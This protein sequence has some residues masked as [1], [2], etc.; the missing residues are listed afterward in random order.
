MEDFWR[1]RQVLEIV[2]KK[3]QSWAGSGG[4]SGILSTARLYDWAAGAISN[5]QLKTACAAAGAMT[6]G[7][8]SAD[9]DAGIRIKQ[10]GA[11]RI[12]TGRQHHILPDAAGIFLLDDDGRL[13][14]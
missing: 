9:P 3:L 7:R 14:F 10:E 8:L 4:K 5:G 12:E 1:L 13:V 2:G 11:F 6:F